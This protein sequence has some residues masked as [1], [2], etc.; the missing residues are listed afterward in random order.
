MDHDDALSQILRSLHL[1]SGLISRG[2]FTAP[3]GAATGPGSRAIFH[4]VVQGSCVAQRDGDPVPVTLHAGEMVIFTRG[5]GH[6]IRDAPDT[7]PEPITTLPSRRVGGLMQ[8]EHGGGGTPCHILCGHFE[9]DQAAS[10]LGDLLPPMLVIRKAQSTLVE[11]L[12]TTL[13]LISFELDNR[14]QGSDEILR[15][16]TDILFV[17]ALRTYALNLAPGAGGWLGAVH[18]ERIAR[19]LALLH[20]RPE[21]AWTAEGL[22]RKV[23]MSRSG[24]YARFTELVGEGP[25]KYLTRW[26]M[27]VAMDHML[28]GDLSTAELA[29]Q[30]GYSSEDAFSRAF[31]RTVGVTPSVWR[32][33]HAV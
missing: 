31:R 24:F 4:A 13:G 5:D 32:R 28:Q 11:W 14:R 33:T 6:V 3:W 16:L 8:V 7:R 27:R 10:T 2:H 23:G 26:R 25:S 17:Q 9:L 20:Q 22:A 19:A 15:R 1:S 12:E 18:D 29:E 30:V 21:H